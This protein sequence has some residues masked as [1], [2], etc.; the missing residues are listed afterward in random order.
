MWLAITIASQIS[1]GPAETSKNQNNSNAVATNNQGEQTAKKKTIRDALNNLVNKLESGLKFTKYQTYEEF[2][3]DFNSIRRR[4]LSEESAVSSNMKNLISESLNEEQQSLL[5][6]YLK[7]WRPILA[8]YNVIKLDD[9]CTLDHINDIIQYHERYLGLYG[10]VD[11]RKLP[12]TERKK[13]TSKVKRLLSS[14]VTEKDPMENVAPPLIDDIFRNYVNT[15]S[16]KCST[17]INDHI[18]DSEWLVRQDLNELCNLVKCAQ[19]V[20]YTPSDECTLNQ[21]SIRQVNLGSDKAIYKK[22]LS[23]YI[24]HALVDK[25]G[26]DR[27]VLAY[28]NAFKSLLVDSCLRLEQMYSGSLQTIMRLSMLGYAI[29]SHHLDKKYVD[30]WVQV[31]Q[32]CDTLL[33]TRVDVLVDGRGRNTIEMIMRK[34][35][36]YKQLKPMNHYESLADNE[37]VFQIE[38]TNEEQQLLV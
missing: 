22:A 34:Q 15:V 24:N 17:D 31:M 36:A 23:K 28:V 25:L 8:L 26:E 30:K 33:K 32:L 21:H 12:A 27:G 18:K 19:D 4:Y 3:K 5:L 37:I 35:R 20:D 29:N 13:Q 38:A 1:C 10:M 16:L 11:V 6:K 14:D 7:A 2:T 9:I